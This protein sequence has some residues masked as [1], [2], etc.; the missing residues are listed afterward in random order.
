MVGIYDL[1]C[2]GSLKDIAPDKLKDGMHVIIYITTE[3]EMEAVLEF[4]TKYDRWTARP[5]QG[6]IN[7]LD[8][9]AQ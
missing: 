3:V 2:S 4:D 5:I 1:A 9:S 6:T 8:E 7:Y